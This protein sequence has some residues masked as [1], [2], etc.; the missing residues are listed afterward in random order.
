MDYF[1]FY[2]DSGPTKRQNLFTFTVIVGAVI[3]LIFNLVLIPRYYSIGAAVASVIAESVIAILQLFLVRHELSFGIV[4]KRSWKYLVS[5]SVMFLI[6]LFAEKRLQPSIVNTLILFTVGVISYF[7]F[8]LILRDKFFLE[9]GRN[10][11]NKILKKGR[12]E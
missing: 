5:G 1:I 4:L 7:S 2:T 10:V 6:L 9:N 3:N 11:I 12:L 8:L